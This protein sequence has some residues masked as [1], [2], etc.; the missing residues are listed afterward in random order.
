LCLTGW[1]PLFSSNI[2]LLK[3]LLGLLDSSSG[4]IKLACRDLIAKFTDKVRL[5]EV[6]VVQ[7][8]V[9]AGLREQEPV[10][11]E[12]SFELLTS[13]PD[14]P[15]EL[16]KANLWPSLFEYMQ[17]KNASLFV[18]ELL[19]CFIGSYSGMGMVTL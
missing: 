3:A 12:S 11:V 8:L 6:G 5:I 16:L 4:Q 10:H 18:V 9:E 17:R 1:Q 19:L 14:A 2:R 7:R 13:I 15:L